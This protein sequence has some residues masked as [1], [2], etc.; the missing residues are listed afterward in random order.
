MCISDVKIAAVILLAH[1]LPSKSSRYFYLVSCVQARAAH[2]QFS[3]FLFLSLLFLPPTVTLSLTWEWMLALEYSALPLL[4][5]VVMICPYGAPSLCSLIGAPSGLSFTS[6]AT[7]A[8]LVPDTRWDMVGQVLHVQS[9]GL[10]IFVFSFF[11]Y[12]LLLYAV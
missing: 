4:Y 3:A 6:E 9:L 5:S 7:C 11:L 2:T 8:Q 10:F 12:I 1:C